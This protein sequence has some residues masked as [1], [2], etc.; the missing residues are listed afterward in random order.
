MYIYG[1][2]PTYLYIKQHSVTGKLYFGKTIQDPEA[3]LGSGLHWK[4]HIKKH[5]KE[6][7]VTLWYC[8]F[9]DQESCTEFALS[10]SELHDIVDSDEWLNRILETGSDNSIGQTKG[11]THSKETKLK[12]S[13]DRKGIPKKPF[14][15]QHLQNLR[16]PK[17][18]TTKMHK[19]KS[20]EHK[21]KLSE[22][23]K[24]NILL[25]ALLLK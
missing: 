9:L 13:K 2:N 7:V 14:S 10:F 6:H 3:Y 20:E 17:S 16:K 18:D 23:R 21:K 5:G 12:M 1:F 4:N 24:R 11:F 22:A 25:A 19:P 15:D 8:L